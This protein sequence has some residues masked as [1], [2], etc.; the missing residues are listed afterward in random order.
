MK[1]EESHVEKNLENFFGGKPA[2]NKKVLIE[3]I[4]ED[5]YISE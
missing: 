5:T 2:E 4:K 1:K 3:E